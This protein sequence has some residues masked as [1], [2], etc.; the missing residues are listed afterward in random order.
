LR[1]HREVEAN[2]KG[3]FLELLD[4]VGEHDPIVKSRLKDGPRNATYTAHGIQDEI[5]H[6]LERNVRIK[7]CQEIKIADYYSIIVD[8]SRDVAN[9]EQLSFV[10]R[11]F[12]LNDG[13][14]LERC[15]TFFHAKCQNA[16]SLS[17]Y[18][19]D[20]IVEFDFDCHKLVNQGYDGA[21]VMSGQ[22]TG[23]QAHVREF[24]PYA[25][26]V[27]CYAHILNLVLVDSLQPARGTLCVSVQIKGSQSVC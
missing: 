3:N 8:E 23:V 27:H 21:S 2:N 24:A 6:L 16:A 13:K 10:V 7:I 11:Y 4:L 20:L 15:L 14:I 9:H 26:Y 18:T 12:N 19:H 1:G 22:Y 5:L 25:V 17:Q